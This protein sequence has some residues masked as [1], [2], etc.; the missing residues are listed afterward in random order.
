MISQDSGK[1]LADGL[2]GPWLSKA[3][4]DS[5]EPRT[6]QFLPIIQ[7][8][9]RDWF[10]RN[11]VDEGEQTQA[12]YRY[13]QT[14]A[15]LPLAYGA[16]LNA[17]IM[18]RDPL[19][20]MA[21]IF[22]LSAASELQ[23]LSLL[24]KTIT[25][26]IDYKSLQEKKPTLANLLY[27]REILSAHSEKMRELVHWIKRYRSRN[28][29]HVAIE[30]EHLRREAEAVTNNLLTDFEHLVRRADLLSERCNTGMAVIGNNAMLDES[31]KAI[32]QARVVAR[33]TFI[34]F[35]FVPLS[36]T[37][38][39]FGMNVSQLGTGK[40]SIGVWA[41][42]SSVVLLMTTLIFF[43]DR[44]TVAG[45][46]TIMSALIARLLRREQKLC[47][48]DADGIQMV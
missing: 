11:T 47:A 44:N 36:F 24:D 31:R 6:T 34:A 42:V 33:L 27:C 14:A 21:E 37:T 19:Y 22:R 30:D 46:R 48:D 9:K 29:L 25:R 35:I 12:H 26:D 5:T 38:S 43:V 16:S 20:A 3:E 23:V 40:L 41:A 10:K 7:H 39:L 15:L 17:T 18:A 13:P 1:S 28:D 45:A 4:R 32:S 8:G 2:E